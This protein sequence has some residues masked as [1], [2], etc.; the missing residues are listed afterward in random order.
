[1]NSKNSNIL[2]IMLLV[3]DLFTKFLFHNFNIDVDII[4]HILSLEL[5][6]NSGISFGM[7]GHS[8][9]LV[10][11]I[12]SMIIMLLVYMYLKTKNNTNKFGILM[13][14]IG[15][16]SNLLDRLLFG[17]VIDFINIKLFVCNLADIYIFLGAMILILNVDGKHGNNN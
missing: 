4:P 15:A 16:C 1:M 13:M 8:P 14:I 5:V 17:Y 6:K 3:V 10:I 11:V 2:A 7:F 9:M 12:T